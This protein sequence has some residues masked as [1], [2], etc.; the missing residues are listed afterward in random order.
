MF[1]TH[2]FEIFDLDPTVGVQVVP[3]QRLLEQAAFLAGAPREWP[4]EA[5]RPYSELQNFGPYQPPL[6]PYP[7]Q[8]SG[9]VLIWGAAEQFDLPQLRELLLQRYPPVHPIQLAVFT[10]NNIAYEHTTSLA[11][12]ANVESSQFSV[13]SAQAALHL[14]PLPIAADLRSLDGLT[15]VVARLYGPAG[16]PW[17]RQQTHQSLRGALLEEAY[18]VLEAL[19]NND[20]P[21]LREELGDL[22]LSVVAQSEMARQSGQFDLGAVLE[23]VSSKLINRH[24]HVFG[25]LAVSGTGEVLHN[26]EQIKAQ[27]LAAKGRS[28]ASALDGI[29]AGLPALAAAEKLAKKASRAGFSWPDSAGAWAKLEEELAELRAAVPAA[30][31]AHIAEEFGDLLFTLV[32]LA[33]WLHIDPEIALRE[34]NAKF[35]RRFVA[36]EQA[37][38]A[39]GV[40]LNELSLEHMLALWQAAK[41]DK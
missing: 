30:N 11:A 18:E 25:E 26:W 12:L 32:V 19:D 15:W 29:P 16:C 23:G 38:A 1:P 3:A 39:Q 34:A 35:R 9:H 31:P 24:P 2:L 36:V 17:D 7:I 5:D 27:E 13:L 8:P 4:K 14:P 41:N 20:M 10:N 33:R 37:A 40:R 28:R 6:L 21:G 22:L